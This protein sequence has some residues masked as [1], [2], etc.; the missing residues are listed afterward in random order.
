MELDL[1]DKLLNTTK[2]NKITQSFI[3]ELTN[4]L[5]NVNNE[6]NLSILELVQNDKKITVKYRD[7][8]YIERDNILNNYAKRTVQEG[9]MCYIYSKSSNKDNNFNLFIC[10]EEKS[11][12]IIQVN[13]KDL[14]D[15]AKIDSV[16]RIKN[17][18]YIL[19]KEATEEISE[20]ITD[21]INKLLEE[22]MQELAEQRIEG[23]IYEVGEIEKDRVWLF[24]ITD[25]N[26]SELNGIEEIDFPKEILNDVTEGAIVEYKNGNYKIYEKK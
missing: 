13:Q 9:S 15:G 7:K 25:D 6:R 3:N 12:E 22:Q 14:P 11:H 8:M 1:F 5:D 23:H 16:L 2:E 10:E 24:D 21:M 20:E 19:D 18:K 26:K 17:G 4:F